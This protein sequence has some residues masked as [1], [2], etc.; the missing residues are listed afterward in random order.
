MRGSADQ[1][2]EAAHAEQD[3]IS[4]KMGELSEIVQQ[5]TDER[6]EIVNLLPSIDDEIASVEGQIREELPDIREAQGKIV[7]VI[8]A[9]DATQSA[10]ADT[11][12]L[13]NSRG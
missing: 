4:L 9:R 5:L 11:K 2:T 13:N 10:L 3:K 6:S 1:I 12:T 7:A 8:S